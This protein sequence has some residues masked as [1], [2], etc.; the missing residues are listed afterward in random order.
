MKSHILVLS[1]CFFQLAGCC[2][3]TDHQEKPEIP[4]IFE[5][6]IGGDIDDALAL[7]LLYKYADMG[8]VRFRGISTCHNTPHSIEFVDLMNTWYGHP[9]LP[10][11]KIP[12]EDY[13]WNGYAKKTCLYQVN[14]ESPFKRTHDDYEKIPESPLFYRELLAIQPDN[15]V[16]LISVGGSTNLARLLDTRPDQFSPLTGKELVAQ[17]VK[18]LSMMAGSTDNT[19]KEWNVFINIPAAQKILREWPT[20]IVISP[21]EVGASIIIPA[22][23]FENNLNYVS[24][25]PLKIACENFTGNS[26]QFPFDVGTCDLTSV[27]YAVEGTENYFNIRWG[28]MDADDYGCTRFYPDE[29]G[30]HGI[31]SVNKEQKEIVKNRFIELMSM[32][33]ANK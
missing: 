21:F 10:M 19:Y 30:K 18:L 33:P 23:V 16:T 24:P 14:G 2:S 8:L 11:G 15:S 26:K 4:V 5:T 22:T 7:D 3:S 27:L 31:L 6:D 28:R 17:K 29:N 25:H 12:V 13:E 9:E 32:K 20:T 1:I